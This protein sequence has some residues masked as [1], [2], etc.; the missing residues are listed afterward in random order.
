MKQNNLNKNSKET[1]FN[2]KDLSSLSINFTPTKIDNPYLINSEEKNLKKDLNTSLKKPISFKDKNFNTTSSNNYFYDSNKNNID[3]KKYPYDHII[4]SIELLEKH[5]LDFK[6][7]LRKS[8]IQN[9]DKKYPNNNTKTDNYIINYQLNNNI[10]SP[11]YI[12]NNLSLYN[13]EHFENQ[14]K[15]NLMEKKRQFLIIKN[16]ELEKEIKKLDN[17]FDKNYKKFTKSNSENQNNKN[18]EENLSIMEQNARMRN[19]IKE[20]DKNIYNLKNQIE[21]AKILCMRKEETNNFNSNTLKEIQLWKKRCSQ[22]TDNY[23]KNLHNIKNELKKDKLSFK[24]EI[25]DIKNKFEKNINEMYERYFN[26]MQK[27]EKNIKI[28]QKENS[29]LSEKERK[30]KEV[31]L[32]NFS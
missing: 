31:F 19:Q 18:K 4:P 30:I 1:K 11:N 2:N 5:L 25:K 21:N 23:I 3:K 7:N 28:L 14:N 26:L 8:D 20:L 6:Q 27:N 16:N 13:N 15:I 22:L 9:Y 29:D 17:M 10:P 32:Y 24:N 12:K